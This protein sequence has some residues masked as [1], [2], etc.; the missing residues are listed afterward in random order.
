[1]AAGINPKSN[2]ELDPGQST[3]QHSFK[4][5]RDNTVNFVRNYWPVF[6]VA[7][8]TLTLGLKEYF[9][10]V[11]IFTFC[12]LTWSDLNLW[13]SIPLFLVGSTATYQRQTKTEKMSVCI[14]QQ[15]VTIE[16]LGEA[17]EQTRG[18]YFWLVE[19]HLQFVFAHLHLAATDRITLYRF[20]DSQIGFVRLG[21]Y[22]LNEEWRM[23]SGRAIYPED[24]GVIGMAWKYGMASL[25]L[26]GQVGEKAYIEAQR[27]YGK[28]PK[29]ICQ[30]LRMPSRSYLGFMLKDSS[31]RNKSA[32]IIFESV[33]GQKFENRAQVIKD[34]I[35]GELG[36]NLIRFVD[37]YR[38][39]EPHPKIAESEGF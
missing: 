11:P 9:R 13:I 7:F 38:I 32:V 29:R 8:T 15:R 26:A 39:L 17:L 36:R 10:A 24:E 2:G 37:C 33:E 34:N 28:L 27:D 30:K 25:E 22:A 20:D 31:G 19:T 4:Q 12:G 18:D 1:M 21:R 23:P 3:S 35:E 16:S 14:R 6:T 5:Q